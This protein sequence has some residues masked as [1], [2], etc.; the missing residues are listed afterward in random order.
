MAE[1]H[2]RGRCGVS[3]VAGQQRWI[4]QPGRAG[5]CG[6]LQLAIDHRVGGHVG[7][8]AL[9]QGCHLIQKA[10]GPGDHLRTAC[11]IVAPAGGQAAQRIGAVEGVVQAAP[12]GI[13]GVERIAGVHHRHHQLRAGYLRDGI[14]HVGGVDG[15]I[16]PLR[17]QIADV[18]Q[19]GPVG[20]HVGDGTGVGAVP[21]VDLLLDFVPFGQQ[22]TVF[23]AQVVNQGRQPLPEG[24]GGYTSTGQRFPLDHVMKGGRHLKA[25]FLDTA[26]HVRVSLKWVWSVP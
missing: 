2:G 6:G 10:L 26:G 16:R 19:K 7:M 22:G 15:K 12:A 21:G 25:E 11:R 3:L 20:G 17:H 14:V 5:R 18:R 13:G 1:Q 4:L 9:R 24:V 8:A 23:R